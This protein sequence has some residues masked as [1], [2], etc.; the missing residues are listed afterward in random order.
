MPKHL[1]LEEMQLFQAGEPVIPELQRAVIIGLRAWCHTRCPM[2][3]VMK[4]PKMCAKLRLQEKNNVTYIVDDLLGNGVRS[5]HLEEGFLPPFELNRLLYDDFS[6]AV[7][8]FGVW[9]D[10]QESCRGTAVHSIHNKAYLFHVDGN[11]TSTTLR[12][13]VR[14]ISHGWK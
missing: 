9:R 2:A 5:K 4:L 11:R 12:Y 6:W 10:R 8:Y 14:M 7:W 3:H 1:V 13:I